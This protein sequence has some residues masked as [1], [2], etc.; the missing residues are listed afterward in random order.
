MNF[1]AGYIIDGVSDVINREISNKGFF[2]TKQN[3][4]KVNALQ[5][6]LENASTFTINFKEVESINYLEINP[7][8]AVQSNILSRGLPTRAPL[9]IEKIFKKIGLTSKDLDK[10]YEEKFILN[11][12]KLSFEDYFELLHIIKPNLD[13]SRENYSGNLDS[14]LEWRFLE[15]SNPVFKQ[16]LQS[17]REFETLVTNFGGKRRLDFSFTK[18]YKTYNGL[19]QKFEYQTLVFEVDG[20]HHLLKEHIIYD[21]LRDEN[22]KEANGNVIRFSHFDISNFSKSAS[23]YLQEDILKIHTKNFDR[24]IKED[25]GK[26]TLA[27]LPFSVAR[28]QKTLVEIF[29]R[30]PE[31]LQ[32]EILNICVIERDIPGSAIAVEIFKDFISNINPLLKTESQLE[33]PDF[34]VKLL[35][36]DSWLINEEINCGYSKIGWSDFN[37]ENFDFVIDNSVLLREGVFNFNNTIN[38]DFYTV[39]SCHYVDNSIENSRLIYCAESL[40]YKPLV[41]RNEDTSY[42]NDALLYPH[43]TYFLTNIFRK[44]DFREGQLPIISRALQKLPVIGL[45]PT[46]GGKSLTF[47][48]PAFMQPC[49]TIVVDPIKSLMEDQVRVLRENWIDSITYA[50]SSQSSQEKNKSIVDFKLASKQIIFVSPERFV[51]ES[52]RDIVQ[53][54]HTTGTGQG[55]GYCVIDEVHCLSEWGH[56]FRYDYLMLGD[57][58]QK[59]CYTR[60]TDFLGTPIPVSLIGLTATASFDVLADIE[61]ELKIK[62]NDIAQATIMIE[63]TI[64]PELF[65]RVVRVPLKKDRSEF[66]LHEM[67]NLS[68]S[69]SYFNNEELMYQSQLHHFKNFDEKDFCKR[70]GS[71]L[72]YDEN[73]NLIFSYAPKLVNSNPLGQFCSITFC[74]VKG[75]SENDEGDFLNKKGVRNTHRKIRENGILATYYHGTDNGIEQSQIQENFIKFT[76]GAVPHMVCTKAFGM[77]I[78]KDDVR[79]TFHINYSSSLESLTQECGRAGRDKKTALSTIF[80]NPNNQIAFNYLKLPSF[81]A[82]LNSFHFYIIKQ[83]FESEEFIT[84]TE[85]EFLEKLDECEFK[86]VSKE[87]KRSELSSFMIKS[88]KQIISKNIKELIYTKSEDRGIH[89]YFFDLAFKGEEYEKSHIHNFFNVKEFPDVDN[90][91]PNFREVFNNL[92]SGEFSFILAFSNYK[93]IDAKSIVSQLLNVTS[94]ELIKQIGIVFKNSKNIEELWFNLQSNGICKIDDINEIKKVQ[95]E[96][97]F[98]ALRNEIET[99]RL[100]Y[101]LHSVGLLKSYT[102]DYNKH[103]YHCVFYKDENVDYYIDK[104]ATFLRRYQSEISV[105]KSIAILNEKLSFA[106]QNLL[107]DIQLILFHLIEFAMH[108]I[109]GKRR[110]ATDDI[111]KIMDDMATSDRGDFENNIYLKEQM[112][113]YFNA[114]Y[115]KPEYVEN[116]ID[117][118]LLDDYRKYQGKI[119]NPFDI[120]KKYM[121]DDII[122]SGTEQNNYK[123]LIGSCKKI[124]FSLVEK[125]LKEDW[126]L[127]LLNAFAMYS[128]NNIS[129]RNEANKVIEVGFE[130]LFDNDHYHTNDYKLISDIF[131]VYFEKLTLN[132]NNK[133]PALLD[134][135]LVKNKLLQTLQLKQV[136]ELLDNYYTL[137]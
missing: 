25:L 72:I 121:S 128:T 124:T 26:Y 119:M 15:N 133:N 118:S 104:I 3:N 59:Y 63:N 9:R 6:L 96:A 117:C 134:I 70:N 5:G 111:K 80:V 18:P 12:S 78:D 123:H 136:S 116:N 61:R 43:I 95:I 85:K 37:A 113:F 66:L 103:Q 127:K 11:E 32:K 30:K 60:D 106:P 64:R 8:L 76:G 20:P 93:S 100:V 19:N 27:L 82:G 105:E 73:Q 91:Q 126:L 45:L 16:I 13:I 29:I 109:A 137:N 40:K 23:E 89:D 94:E 125:E 36:D 44:K 75:T 4:I 107:D 92:D 34:N 48:I 98:F 90:I 65:F 35:Q 114:K 55:I 88:L 46:G 14:H 53:H 68:T 87:G 81:Y 97:P 28:I 102:K 83:N 47:Q 79:A 71:E 49:L 33:I 115:S 99:G 135:D 10:Q 86:A 132:L 42:T 74:A 52:F 56:D 69:Y 101:R 108:E 77:G 129:Y 22:I 54:I 120:L 131:K 57:N 58:A 67:N 122:K 38:P 2:T 112:Y 1:Q 31:F 110:R 62:S 7:V 41:F 21:K 130:R 84:Q 17:Q 24:D 39:R 50:N 51:I